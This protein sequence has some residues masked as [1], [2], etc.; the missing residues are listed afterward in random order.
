MYS[1]CCHVFKEEWHNFCLQLPEKTEK[2]QGE[3]LCLIEY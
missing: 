3:A 1:G 2:Q